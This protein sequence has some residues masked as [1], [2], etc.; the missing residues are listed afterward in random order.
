[1]K[2]FI[3]ILAI[4]LIFLLISISGCKNTSKSNKESSTTES[5][6]VEKENEENLNYDYSNEKGTIVKNEGVINELQVFI[7]K[8]YYN[9]LFMPKSE[10]GKITETDMQLFAISYIYQYEYKELRFDVDKFEL[11]IPE[12]NVSEVIKRF[13]NYD[14]TNHKYSENAAINYENGYYLIKAQDKKFGA[15]P[16]IKEAIKYSD[17]N[18][19]VVYSSSSADSKE[20]FEA[21][22][23]EIG[24]RWVLLNFKKI[25]SS[26]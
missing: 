3:S 22:V 8:F 15:K 4:F 2:R 18:Y 19:K 11:Y 7:E 13:F 16:I 21:I 23:K 20:E 6:K 9:F 24:D 14:F 12:E 25:A 17:S 5:R 26:N 1:M 10:T